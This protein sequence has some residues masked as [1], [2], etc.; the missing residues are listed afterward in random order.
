MPLFC[1]HSFFDSSKL[2]KINDIRALHLDYIKQKNCIHYGG[3]ITDENNQ[4]KGIIII[5]YANNLEDA[6]E[7]I[8]NDPY[9]VLYN[10]C[11]TDFFTQRIPTIIHERAL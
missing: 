5:F 1:C 2:D 11:N 9:F 8:E 7:F 3:V 4:H 10:K 6:K